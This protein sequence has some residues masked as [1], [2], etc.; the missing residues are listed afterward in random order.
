YNI[1]NQVHK[2]LRAFMY[3][4]AIVLQR[5]DFT[6]AEDAE[7][8]I[9][10]L[11]DLL[12]LMK[13]HAYAEESIIFPA[14]QKFNRPLV[15]EIL[16]EHE[17]DHSLARR[18]SGLLLAF[19]HGVCADDKADIGKAIYSAFID[20]LVFNLEHMAREEDV[21]NKSLWENFSDGQ[22]IQLSHKAMLKIPCNLVD[23][24]SRWMLRGLTNNE[25][26]EWLK[27]IK[28]NAPESVFSTLMILSETELSGARWQ[29]LQEQLIEGAMV[30]S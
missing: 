28:N 10:Q 23:Q 2:A 6:N 27:D 25:I 4:S 13:D 29:Q 9:N 22:I 24:Y 1:F 17:E 19:S 26:A 12:D 5:T 21:L 7:H 3:D 20:F 30:H 8:S 14:L 16:A 11:N 18:L 15:L